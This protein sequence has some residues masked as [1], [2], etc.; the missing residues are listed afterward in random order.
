MSEN[1]AASGGDDPGQ[2]ADGGIASLRYILEQTIR[3]VGP[4]H[5][6]A[7]VARRQLALAILRSRDGGSLGYVKVFEDHL[8]ETER[9]QGGFSWQAR[10]ARAELG[11]AYRNHLT[12]AREIELYEQHLAAARKDTIEEIWARQDMANVLADTHQLTAAL[13]H[14]EKNYEVSR[15]LRGRY[16]RYT[17][18]ALR[19]RDWARDAIDHRRNDVTEGESAPVERPVM[20]P[21]GRRHAVPLHDGAASA[22]LLGIDRDVDALGRMIAARSTQP[23]LSIALMAPWGGGKSTFMRLLKHKVEVELP[24]RDDDNF[25]TSVD[26]VEFNPWHYS[27]THVMVGMSRA[28]FESLKRYLED[29]DRKRSRPGAN[30]EGSYQ[31]QVADRTALT[32]A[33][34]RLEKT[35]DELRTDSVIQRPRATMLALRTLPNLLF[36]RNHRV[37]RFALMFNAALFAA[38]VIGLIAWEAWGL[39]ALDGARDWLDGLIRSQPALLA[40][41]ALVAAAL[42]GL[43]KQRAIRRKIAAGS[44]WLVGFVAAGVDAEMERLDDEL[45]RTEGSATTKVVADLETILRDPERAA[46]RDAQLGIVGV[47][48]RQFEELAEAVRVDGD[49]RDP[50]RLKRIVLHVDDLDRCRPERV[51]EVLHTLNLLQATGLFVIVVSIDPRWLR[52]AMWDLEPVAAIDLEKAEVGGRLRAEIG[53]PLEFLDK[54]FQIPYALRPM[55]ATNAEDYFT[56]LVGQKELVDPMPPRAVPEAASGGRGGTSG[57]RATE[58]PPA[59]PLTVTP[60]E[61][62]YLRPLAAGQQTPRAVKRFLNLYQLLRLTTSL[63]ME[64]ETEMLGDDVHGDR[65]AAAMLL[66]ILVGAPRQ[67]SELLGEMLKTDHQDSDLAE[68]VDTLQTRHLRDANGR[69]GRGR[70]G[71]VGPCETCAAWLRISMVVTQKTSIEDPPTLVRDFRPWVGEVSRFSF[72]TEAIGLAGVGS[73]AQLDTA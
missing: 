27:D 63:R 59:H 50:L 44:T 47:L 37:M 4:F 20:R 52:R 39:D 35:Q 38:A 66:A 11:E 1:P 48:Q 71:A 29:Q 58:E 22:D 16:D 45:A 6:D 7:R 23:P 64:G 67:G 2:S 41:L 57:P 5:E 73:G 56:S 8:R 54:V 34:Q 51:V 60:R 43:P 24:D 21:P 10:A 19:L 40:A 42:E 68:L 55:N 9:E 32:A 18:R 70:Q 72:H 14:Y 30:G 53:D 65:R 61:W 26:V 17:D 62:D 12:E 46:E 25:H 28:I 3:Q 31:E 49:T 69:H 13:K 36:G 33:R 15:R